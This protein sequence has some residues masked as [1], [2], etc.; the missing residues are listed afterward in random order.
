MQNTAGIVAGIL[1]LAAASTYIVSVVKGKTRPERG[2]MIIW[3]V[4]SGI[5][6]SAYWADGAKASLW[7]AAGDFVVGI[8]MLVLAIKFGYGWANRRH[9]PALGAAAAGL[10]L[11]AITDNPF[12]AL[13]CSLSVDA[14]GYVL[15]VAKSYEAPET[16]HLGSWL[17]YLMGALLGVVAVGHWDFTLLFYPVYAVIATL[18]IVAAILLGRKLGHHGTPQMEREVIDP[19][20]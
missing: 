4:T 15:V 10:A 7:F 5:A 14:V 8:V 20:P 11:W 6:L 12:V 2:A 3:A 18:A 13:L 9:I 1:T 16:E 17:I 19:V